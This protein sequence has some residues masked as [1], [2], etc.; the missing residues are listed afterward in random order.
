MLETEAIRALRAA[1]VP[2]PVR[3]HVIRYDG[4]V[5]A[6]VDL[7]WPDARVYLELDSER[8]H[9]SW[10]ARRRDLARQNRL[11]AA[12]WAPVRHTWA[13]YADGGAAASAEVSAVLKARTAA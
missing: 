2:P 10:T 9:G 5:V 4:Q 1:G 12:G 13:D 7:A 8:H 3:Q 6:R 11:T